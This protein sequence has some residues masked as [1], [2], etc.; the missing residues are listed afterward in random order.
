MSALHRHQIAW[1][2]TPGWQR[3]LKRDWDAEARDC[4]CHWAKH[5]LPLVVTRQSDEST[6][7]IAMGLCAPQ[8]WHYRRMALRA[9]RD[10]VL[11]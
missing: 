9:Q 6:E 4:L 10:E 2:T 7:A 5:G 8:R 1:L 11:Y 3:L